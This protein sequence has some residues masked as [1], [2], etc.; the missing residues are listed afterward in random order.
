[1]TAP[2]LEAELD[3]LAD[4]ICDLVVQPDDKGVRARIKER[5][6]AL[7]YAFCEGK[8]ID[9]SSLEVA[10]KE[11]FAIVERRLIAKNLDP[12]FAIVAL[13]KMVYEEFGSRSISKSRRVT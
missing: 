5:G 1:M 6:A 13:T 3:E 4:A 2:D 11:I 7:L 12:T 8:H 9:W 10:K